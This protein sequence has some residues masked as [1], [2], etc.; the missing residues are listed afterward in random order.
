[1]WTGI[2]DAAALVG[3]SE[4]HNV[5]ILDARTHTPGTFH[6]TGFTLIKLDQV[7]KHSSLLSYQVL[8]VGIQ[9]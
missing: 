9:N 7:T 4:M 8:R 3:D 1:M 6:Q 5:T 2:S